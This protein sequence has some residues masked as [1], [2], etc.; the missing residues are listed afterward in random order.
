ML[1]SDICRVKLEQTSFIILELHR[2]QSSLEFNTG[3]S[4]VNNLLLGLD[5]LRQN[6]NPKASA[7]LCS[8]SAEMLYG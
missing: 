8:V 2:Y 5:N 3:T 4:L 1:N 6:L 7:L